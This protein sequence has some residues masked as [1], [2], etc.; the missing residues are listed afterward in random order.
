M[1]QTGKGA[2]AKAVGAENGATAGRRLEQLQVKASPVDGLSIAGDVKLE[3]KT[4]KVQKLL[5]T[6]VYQQT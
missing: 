3:Q 1:A 2:S 5:T 6:K 4:K